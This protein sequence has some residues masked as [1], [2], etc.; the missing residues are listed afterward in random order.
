MFTSFYF[1]FAFFSTYRFFWGF[2]VFF[3]LK[4][5]YTRFSLKHY[6]LFLYAVYQ[7][8]LVLRKLEE[9]PSILIK[10]I[11]FQRGSSL[12]V[13]N[14]KNIPVMFA[15]NGNLFLAHSDIQK[16]F[17]TVNQE[18]ASFS[19]MLTSN[20]LSLN[21]RISKNF[22]ISMFQS[23]KFYIWDEMRI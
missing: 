20:K 16:L 22:F 4:T 3:S 1:C 9:T 6:C 18:L 13:W 14:L 12:T 8:E 21:A 17:S 23:K 10:I 15:D 2:F 19:Q 7:C 5:H 11:F